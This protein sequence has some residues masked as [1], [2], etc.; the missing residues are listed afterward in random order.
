MT[1]SEMAQAIEEA[2]TIIRRSDLYI[3]KMAELMAGRLRNSDVR[4]S[5]LSKLKRELSGWNMHTSS[6]SEE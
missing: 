5:V 1:Y 3:G 6:W 4:A 2:Q